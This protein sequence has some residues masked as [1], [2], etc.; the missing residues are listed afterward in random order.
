VL[1]HRDRHG[2]GLAQIGRQTVAETVRELLG[3]HV[4]V[5]HLPIRV[6]DYA[7]KEVSAEKAWRLLGWRATTLFEDGMRRYV[8]DYLTARVAEESDVPLVTGD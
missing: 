5:V 3:D 2:G 7:G 1:V 4:R 6:G 8:D